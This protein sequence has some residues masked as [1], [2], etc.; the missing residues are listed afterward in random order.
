M[1]NVFTELGRRLTAFGTDAASRQVVERACRANGW[2]MPDEVIEAISALCSQMLDGQK[3]TEFISRY[4][5]PVAAPKRVG[6]VM[7]GNIP[8]AGFYDMMC[9]LVSGHACL[10]KP[11][12]KDRPLMEYTVQQIKD[13]APTAPLYY[14]DGAVEMEAVVATGSDNSGRYFRS[15]WRA[16]PSIIR[17]SRSSVAILHSNETV[18]QLEG[19]ARDIF[20]YSG[21]G[22]RN[23]SRV[24]V[25][26]NYPLQHLADALQCYSGAVN[27][28]YRHNYLRH[29]AI[30]TMQGARFVDGGFFLLTEGD[31]FPLQLS[32]I[33]C[34]HYRDA[35]HLEM[36][37]ARDETR[38]QCIVADR[39]THKLAVPFGEAQRPTLTDFPDGVDVVSFL[40][41][42]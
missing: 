10:V 4:N 42:L 21:L 11:S 8:L 31:G 5:L 30:L 37:L 24:F 38:L 1:V 25:P 20:S 26:E 14:M 15:R 13:I 16:I 19:L 41:K 2:F 12:S 27:P 7:A 36:L 17:G 23:V 9:V 6:V 39:F 40:E 18:R 35:T 32:E 3:L 34:T 33:A 22:C 29:R 28:R